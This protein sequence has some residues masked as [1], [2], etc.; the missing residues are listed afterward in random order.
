MKLVIFGGGS[1][2]TP[3]LIEGLIRR[4]D[5]LPVT[6]RERPCL[7]YYINR[8]LAPCV[9]WQSVEDYRRMIDEVVGVLEG[10]TTDLRSRI[11][12]TMLEA[13]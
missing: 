5:D 13:S 4:H 1:S 7:D 9:G 11:R 6:R 12:T 10:R 3:E 8:C 2:Y